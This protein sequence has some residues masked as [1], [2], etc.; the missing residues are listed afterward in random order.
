MACCREDGGLVGTP[1]VAFSKYRS[2]WDLVECSF[3]PPNKL[4]VKRPFVLASSYTWL[5]LLREIVCATPPVKLHLV[6]VRICLWRRDGG[7]FASE[8][9]DGSNFLGGREMCILEPKEFKMRRPKG[10]RA[11]TARTTDDDPAEV[12]TQAAAD[13][14]AADLSALAQGCDYDD[15][16]SLERELALI[17]EEVGSDA[18]TDSDD[19]VAGEAV[20]VVVVVVVVLVLVLVLVLVVVVCVG[21]C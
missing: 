4:F 1:L 10:L 14:L 6:H 15:D 5:K 19:E 13:E 9:L 18:G 3:E 7:T 16:D 21:F 20:V 2:V 11:K 12:E 8:L 17:M